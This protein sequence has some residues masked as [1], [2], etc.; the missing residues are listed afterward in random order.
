MGKKASQFD[1]SVSPSFE[2][3][4]EEQHD[5]PHRKVTIVTW[6]KSH[7]L[8]KSWKKKQNKTNPVTSKKA[9]EFSSKEESLKA[10][11]SLPEIDIL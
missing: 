6:D 10:V 9:M 3:V 5:Y 4:R 8:L 7:I 2:W 1:R 11:S